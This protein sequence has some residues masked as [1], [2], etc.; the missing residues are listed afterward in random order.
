MKIFFSS[1]PTDEYS[2]ITNYPYDSL[3]INQKPYPTPRTICFFHLL[4]GK[5]IKGYDKN[6]KRIFSIH[7]PQTLTFV[8]YTPGS[9][10]F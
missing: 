4:Q 10:D 5:F 1:V 6:G 7:L 8:S 3:Q 9:I 2:I